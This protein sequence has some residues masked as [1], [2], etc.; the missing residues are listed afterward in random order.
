M[1]VVPTRPLVYLLQFFL[2]H[3]GKVFG[4]R[5]ASRPK[6]PESSPGE[7]QQGTVSYTAYDNDIHIRTSESFMGPTGTV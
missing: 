2:F 3:C 5:L 7:P 6:D 1:S 4:N